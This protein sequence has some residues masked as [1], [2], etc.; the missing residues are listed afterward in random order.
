MPGADAAA[1]V[2][3]RR[4]VRV[5]FAVGASETIAAELERA[6]FA[7]P[8]LLSTPGRSGVLER[9]AASLTDVA[10]VFDR[11]TL[12]VPTALVS[13][14]REE[15]RHRGAGC[16]VAVGGG[17]AIGLGKAIAESTA[18]P[19]VAVPTT[20]SGSEMTSIWGITDSGGK[21][22]ARHP[23]AAP[24][25]VIYDPELTLTLPPAATAASA[26]NAAAHAVEALYAPDAAP[27][28]SL[29]A[30]A[31]LRQLAQALPDVIADGRDLAART[32][33]LRAA[34]LAGLALDETTMGLQ[35]R[36]AHVLGGTFG[37]PHGETHAALLP[38]LVAFNERAAPEA[39]AT[40]ASAL[41]ADSAGR[42][43]R[44]LA[45]GAGVTYTLRDLGLREEDL[46]RAADLA[47]RNPP[48]NPRAP[49]R[50]DVVALLRDAL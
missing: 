34:Y 49:A 12:H 20:Y 24:A 26:L 39:M 31:A 19:L 29:A 17:S 2:W 32:A 1:F 43:V 9:V 4:A 37:L 21:R 48:P 25:V 46:E 14:A 13:A 41:G 40:I 6:Q 35:H 27:L 10:G 50:A 11:A 18:L 30:E 16:L 38:H 23:R 33:L 28:S 47:T 8:F 15:A 22:T 44:D 36:M 3:H 7:R 5:V 45:R 42:G